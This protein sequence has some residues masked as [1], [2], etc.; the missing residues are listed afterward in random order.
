MSE[1]NEPHSG[2]DLDRTDAS[3]VMLTAFTREENVQTV[4]DIKRSLHVSEVI[5]YMLIPAIPRHHS[6]FIPLFILWHVLRAQSEAAYLMISDVL[7]I[8]QACKTA[9]DVHLNTAVKCV[10][11]SA[12]LLG[13]AVE[14]ICFISDLDQADVSNTI[15][16]AFGLSRSLRSMLHYSCE[17]Q[18]DSGAFSDVAVRSRLDNAVG[19]LL[20]DLVLQTI[21]IT[22]AQATSSIMHGPISLPFTPRNKVCGHDY[23]ADLMTALTCVIVQRVDC[24]HSLTWDFMIYC[25]RNHIIIPFHSVGYGANVSLIHLDMAGAIRNVFLE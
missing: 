6:I 11:K 23:C 5:Q 15:G 7:H 17:A 22:P 9:L 10:M 25:I 16:D 20:Q 14:L 21:T 4:A 8:C 12:D 18:G 2:G 1:I 19:Q 13:Y 24:I 3:I